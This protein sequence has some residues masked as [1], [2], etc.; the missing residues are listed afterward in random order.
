[1]TQATAA[2]AQSVAMFFYGF[3]SLFNGLKPTP[4]AYPAFIRWGIWCSPTYYAMS[5]VTVRGLVDLGDEFTEAATKA[6][7][8]REA[9]SYGAIPPPYTYLLFA[10]FI[11]G[12]KVASVISLNRLKQAK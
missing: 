4:S 9:V 2:E 5:A 8:F 1:M 3:L 11:F 6:I 12:F 10:I 7:G